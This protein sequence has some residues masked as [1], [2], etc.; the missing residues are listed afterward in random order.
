MTVEPGDEVEVGSLPMWR[1]PVT[2]LGVRK[3]GVLYV[4]DSQG[5]TIEVDPVNAAHTVEPVEAE[6]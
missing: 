4:E 6:E 2:V 1:N 5:A 3:S